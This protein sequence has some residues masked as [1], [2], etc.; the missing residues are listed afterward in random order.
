MNRVMF[1]FAT[2]RSSMISR[3][4]AAGSKTP[5]SQLR[6]DRTMEADSAA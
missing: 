5:R 2:K 6:T 3:I 4:S 1:I